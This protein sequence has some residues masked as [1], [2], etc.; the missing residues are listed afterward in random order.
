[1]LEKESIMVV[2]YELKIPSLGINVR[3]HP[4][5]LVMPD[6]YSRDGILSPHLTA[7]KDSYNACQVFLREVITCNVIISIIVVCVRVV[8]MTKVVCKSGQSVNLQR[9]QRRQS[10]KPHSPLRPLAAHLRRILPSGRAHALADTN[11]RCSRSL[12]GRLRR[13]PAQFHM[14]KI[15]MILLSARASC[16]TFTDHSKPNLY[17]SVNILRYF[18]DI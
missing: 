15:N 18:G 6:S 17:V 7:I 14:S 13:A 1:M 12:P 9:T 4:A 8:P 3:H 11:S 16:A 10:A 5:S 2:R